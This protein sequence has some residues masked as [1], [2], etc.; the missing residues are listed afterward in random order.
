MQYTCRH[1]MITVESVLCPSCRQF[2]SNNLDVVEAGMRPLEMP[3]RGL[4][5]F[6]SVGHWGDVFMCVG[7][8]KRLLELAG[9]ERGNVLYV[10]PDLKIVEWLRAQEFVDEAL[11]VRI[12]NADIYPEFW[13]KSV[14]VGVEVR[15]WLPILEPLCN[16]LPAWWQVTQTHINAHWF[17][18]VPAALWHGGRLPGSAWAWAEGALAS[19]K[20]A[21]APRNAQRGEVGAGARGWW[22]AIGGAGKRGVG[23]LAP[24][25]DPLLIHLHPVSVWSETAENH[26]PFWVR[27]I[28]WLLE[29]TPHTYVLTGQ[30]AIEGLCPHPR[31]VDLIGQT[32]GNMEVLAISELCDAVISTPNNIA[33]WSVIQRQRALVV[34]N[35]ASRHLSSYYTRFL[36]RGDRMTYLGVDSSFAEFMAAARRFLTT[37]GAEYAEVGRR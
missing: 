9:L 5:W 16:D 33:H 4:D 36:R 15:D 14:E 29:E 32:P 12:T 3:R 2:L 23:S 26:W 37:E 1:C 17:H 35:A 6:T 24:G 28:E 8:I 27:A 19:R 18:C 25:S 30:K 31:L 21:K 11:G 20:D 34:G 7:H 13:I 22:N 10:G